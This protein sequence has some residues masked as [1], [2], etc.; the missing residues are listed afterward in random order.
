MLS[1]ARTRIPGLVPRQL[2]AFVIRKYSDQPLYND[3]NTKQNL[4]NASSTNATPTSS[5]GAQDA[6]LQELPEDGGRVGVMQAP[7]RE[8]AW[9]KSQQPRGQAMVGPRFEQTLIEHQVR[10]FRSTGFELQL[11]ILG[12]ILCC[13]LCSSIKFISV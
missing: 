11:D 5:I 3:P 10:R 13:L 1:S 2:Q 8:K 7:N 9:S 12:Y 4:P 6:S